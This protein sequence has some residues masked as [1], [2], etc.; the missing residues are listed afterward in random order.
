MLKQYRYRGKNLQGETVRGVM[1]HYTEDHVIRYLKQKEIW[2]S[3]IQE[4]HP[5]WNSIEGIPFQKKISKKDLSMFFFQLSTMLSIGV[6]M[7]EALETIQEQM[8]PISLRYAIEEIYMLVQQGY[9][10]S[11]SM[12]IQ[13]KFPSFSI[14]SIEVGEKSGGLEHIVRDLGKYY[15]QSNDMF[16]QVKTALT[17]PIFVIITTLLIFI[18][19]LYFLLPIFCDLLNSV[20]DSI[21][22][23]TRKL[24][25]WME[26]IQRTGWMWG[27]GCAFL[28]LS[29]FL[30]TKTKKGTQRWHCFLLHVPIIGSLKIQ[31][32]I[33]HF[34]KTLEILLGSGIP[35]LSALEQSIGMLQN[36]YV[37]FK[38]R[39]SI[40]NVRAG[41]ILSKEMQEYSF[42]PKT[43]IQMVALG[44]KTGDL[45]GM[46]RKAS[47]LYE[48]EMNRNFKQ[49]IVL[50]EPI[51]IVFVACLVGSMIFIVI[52]PV[53]QL[54]NTIGEVL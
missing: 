1:K 43:F 51:L 13:G 16:H 49:L 36:P 45:E 11:L 2:I 22:P 41:N 18:A 28:I 52:Q 44:E 25:Q 21:P 17:Y 42:F 6:S 37:E 20:T 5:I 53:L 38:F 31:W 33:V 50:L 32:M 46:M 39:K 35:L 9:P 29:I 10:L 23:Y 34:A 54:L 27:I 4:R 8:K 30:Y 7:L 3:H 26:F 48:Q 15:E 19:F 14:Y 40:Q 12:K 24:L 47:N